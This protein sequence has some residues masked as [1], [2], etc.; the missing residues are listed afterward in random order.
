MSGI[1]PLEKWVVSNIAYSTGTGSTQGSRLGGWIAFGLHPELLRLMSEAQY[2]AVPRTDSQTSSYLPA[3]EGD[4]S[5]TSE[6]PSYFS[7]ATAIMVITFCMGSV[8]MKSYVGMVAFGSCG[9]S[10]L[11]GIPVPANGDIIPANL[12]VERFGYRAIRIFHIRIR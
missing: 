10:D 5:K 3:T 9:A 2:Q 4:A 12:R 8:L 11:S 1:I 7:F 6:S